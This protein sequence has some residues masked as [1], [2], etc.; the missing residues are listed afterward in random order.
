MTFVVTGLITSALVTLIL[1]SLFTYEEKR[2]ARFFE[3]L[4]SHADVTVLRVLH[5]MEKTLRYIGKDF[6]RQL[7]RYFFHT[8]LRATLALTEWSEVR[9][10]SAITTNRNLAKNAER[11][12]AAR[13]KLEELTLHKAEHALNEEEKRAHK[14][15]V[16]EGK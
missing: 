12:H 7:V 14:D 16:L 6:V 11:E 1:S 8:V 2:G 13:S 4:R 10:K 15:K 9:I 5:A 3:R